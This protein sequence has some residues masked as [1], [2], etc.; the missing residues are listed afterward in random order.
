MRILIIHGYLL[1]G[2]G[3]NQ[4]VQ[5]LARSLCSRGQHIVVTCQDDDPRLDFVTAYLQHRHGGSGPRVVWEQETDYPG[6]CMVYRPDIGKLLPVYVRDSYPGYQ[7]KEFHELSD[8][9]LETYVEKNRSV[10]EGLIEKFAPD[11]LHVNHTVMLPSI[12]RP[13]AERFGVPYFVMVHGSAIEFTVKKD[14]RFLACGAEGLAGASGVIVPSEYMSAGVL[15]VFGRMVEG[16]EGKLV[17]VPP[18]VDTKLF[19]LASGDMNSSIDLLL[20]AVQMR[21]GGISVGDFAGRGDE[22][23]GARSEEDRIDMEVARINALH[24]DWLPEPGIGKK[25]KELAEKERPFL[26]FL[27]KLLETKGI[28]CILPALPLIMKDHPDTALVVVG[29]G[30]LRGLLELMLEAIDGGD[31]R[32][33]KNICEYGNR[34]YLRAEM[35]FDPVL[36]FLNELAGEGTLDEYIGTCRESDVAGSV[37]Y[38]GYLT[39]EEHRYL[40]P[41][42]RALLAPSLAPEAFGLVVTEAMASGVLPI[43]SRHSGLETALGP[44]R[45]V[46]GE[47]ADRFMLGDRGKLVFRIAAAS[48]IALEMNDRDIREKGHRMREAAEGR[49]GWDAVTGRVLE[50]FEKGANNGRGQ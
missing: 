41:Y 17:V 28:Q 43:A 38:T 36:A 15:E 3:S 16:L 20:E 21:A 42:A 7:V 45:D 23:G 9:E 39:P 33:L 5:Y 47:E 12:V 46:W 24:P 8:E 11:V 2:T 30:E 40:L 10:L 26:L 37:I 14:P 19:E 44:L 35:P 4:Y 25:L 13:V 34:K 31:V 18:G 1:R 29:F 50:I 6:T 27:G 22:N 49:F 32:A 48:V